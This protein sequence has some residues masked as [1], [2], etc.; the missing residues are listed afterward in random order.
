VAV[1]ALAEDVVTVVSSAVDEAAEIEVTVATVAIEAIGA[2]VVIVATE[3]TVAN[4][5]SA[6]NVETAETVA[7]SVVDVDE[8]AVTVIVEIIVETI[9]EIFVDEDVAAVA[10]VVLRSLSTTSLLSPA[11]VGSKVSYC[12]FR[13][14]TTKRKAHQ[15]FLRRRHH[16]HQL[17]TMWK[18]TLVGSVPSNTTVMATSET[19]SKAFA[20]TGL[21]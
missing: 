21:T 9:V 1:V 5:E 16:H 3:A 8:D 14:P 19:E 11:W 20:R 4:A 18:A 7:T 17:C 13:R 15:P 10:K 12:R 2:T 6:P